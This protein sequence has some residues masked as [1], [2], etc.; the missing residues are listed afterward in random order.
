MSNLIDNRITT[1]ANTSGA[2]SLEILFGRL[3]NYIP[4]FPGLFALRE[5]KVR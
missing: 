2:L 4:S 1:T 5:S 3:S